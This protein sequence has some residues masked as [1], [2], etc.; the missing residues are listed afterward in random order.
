[1]FLI[2]LILYLARD[3]N[4]SGVMTILSIIGKKEVYSLN[5][6]F[7]KF[8]SYSKHSYYACTERNIFTNFLEFENNHRY[9]R[10]DQGHLE[11]LV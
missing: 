6:L 11:E 8:S 3:E 4:E 2:N 9:Q 1:M 7:G 10:E 5:Y